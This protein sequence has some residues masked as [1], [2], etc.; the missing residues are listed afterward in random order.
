MPPA[1]SFQSIGNPMR[2]SNQI[3]VLEVGMFCFQPDPSLFILFVPFPIGLSEHVVSG[4]IPH[5]GVREILIPDVKPKRPVR[6]RNPE[7]LRGNLGQMIYKKFGGWLKSE[8]SLPGITGRAKGLGLPFEPAF[9][10][11]VLLL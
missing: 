11:G 4:V 1:L 3:F 2:N 5:D 10:S 7:Y 8:L 6:F 9:G